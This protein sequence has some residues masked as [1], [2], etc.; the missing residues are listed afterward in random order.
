MGDH[1]ER[2]VVL[3]TKVEIMEETISE[4]KKDVT[5]IKKSL[6]M[7]MGGLSLLQT[8]ATLWIKFGGPTH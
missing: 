6:W 8:L 7:I 4:I 1:S 5:E 2:L 3:E